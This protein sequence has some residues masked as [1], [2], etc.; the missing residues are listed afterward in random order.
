[1]AQNDIR[2]LFGR[3]QPASRLA[4][5]LSELQE[6]GRI[7]HGRTDRRAPEEGLELGSIGARKARK[8]RNEQFQ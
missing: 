1:M 2:D 8:A 6:R 5:V 3:H 4:Q 7:P